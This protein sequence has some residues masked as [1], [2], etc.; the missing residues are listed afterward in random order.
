M[1]AGNELGRAAFNQMT[2]GHEANLRPLSDTP[3]SPI[4]VTIGDFEFPS[5]EA[6]AG[7]ADRGAPLREVH[8][9]RVLHAR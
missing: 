6:G 9:H 3:G 1:S 8:G 2:E 7:C 4:A 5:T